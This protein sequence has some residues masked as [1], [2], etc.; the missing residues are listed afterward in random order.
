MPQPVVAPRGPR[1]P[2][3][4]IAAELREQIES[5]QLP[6]GSHLPTVVDLAATYGVAVGTINRAIA[7]LRE[8]GLIEVSRG[9]RAVVRRPAQ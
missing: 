1:G 4:V 5:G 2:Y 8:S 9:R 3:E 6:P 7:L